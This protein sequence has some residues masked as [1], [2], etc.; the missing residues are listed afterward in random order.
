MMSSPNSISKKKREIGPI[1][2]PK[3]PPKFQGNY[4]TKTSYYG[5][6]VSQLN[7]VEYSAYELLADPGKARGCS[8]NTFVIHYITHP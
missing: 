4:L 5:L 1:G 2:V 7:T 6:K 8:A 3:V